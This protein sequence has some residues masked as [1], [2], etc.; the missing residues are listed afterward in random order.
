MANRA[1][2]NS[3]IVRRTSLEKYIPIHIYNLKI[4]KIGMLRGGF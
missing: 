1:R 2:K 4:A 3:K